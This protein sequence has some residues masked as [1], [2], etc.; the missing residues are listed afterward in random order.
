MSFHASF[1]HSGESGYPRG[2]LVA[3]DAVYPALF[4][5]E[6]VL[7]DGSVQEGGRV[8]ERAFLEF[9]RR[10]IDLEGGH[11]VQVL[12]GDVGVVVGVAGLPGVA[13]HLMVGWS[14]SV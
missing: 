8:G 4:L 7:V 12:V 9:S 6:M 1:R 2:K 10:G 14:L 3:A 11:Q 13:D 5:L